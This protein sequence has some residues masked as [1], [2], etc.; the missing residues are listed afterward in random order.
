MLNGLRAAGSPVQFWGT[1]SAAEPS[2]RADE[3]GNKNAE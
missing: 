2:A 1:F 3:A